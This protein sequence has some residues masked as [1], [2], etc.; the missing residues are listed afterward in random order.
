MISQYLFS[1][2][3]NTLSFSLMK[4]NYLVLSPVLAGSGLMETHWQRKLNTAKPKEFLKS[5]M[6]SRKMKALMSALQ[7]TFE[8]ET[9]Q[10]VN[11]LSMVSRLIHF[12]FFFFLQS[13][14]VFR[15]IL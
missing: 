9:L 13:E 1:A 2:I 8:E 11:Y 12:F 14:M 15:C 3:T 10:E 5:P 6:F 7:E 4:Y